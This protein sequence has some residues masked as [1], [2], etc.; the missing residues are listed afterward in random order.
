MQPI[1]PADEPIETAAV[2]TTTRWVPSAILD[3]PPGEHVIAL[4]TPHRVMLQALPSRTALLQL[5][6]PKTFEIQIDLEDDAAPLRHVPATDTQGAFLAADLPIE[7]T[8]FYWLVD[9]LQE[10]LDCADPLVG[11]ARGRARLELAETML[12]R[13]RPNRPA[14][15]DSIAAAWEAAVTEL[16]QSAA[17]NEMRRDPNKFVRDLAGF[18]VEHAGSTTFIE[19]VRPWLE[20]SQRHTDLALPALGGRETRFLKVYAQNRLFGATWLAAPAGLVAG[21]QL[22]VAA[23]VMAVWFAGRVLQSRRGK[24]ADALTTSFW[25][26]D[27]GLWRD[28]SL[29][30][31]A[32]RQ[33]GS[34]ETESPGFTHALAGLL[35]T[36]LARA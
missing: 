11:F 20:S 33:F 4:R 10:D 5:L 12:R 6:A 7:W 15:V 17:E 35:R 18:V 24:V 16:P 14:D 2:C 28:D 21:W 26:L 23:H 36:S 1:Q 13:A 8:L 27:E 34:R 31:A 29:V 25:L 19:A 32:V 3:L 30:H 22:F 9:G